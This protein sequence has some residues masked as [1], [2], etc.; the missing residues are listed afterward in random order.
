[1]TRRRPSTVPL[2]LEIDRTELACRLFEG[3]SDRTRYPG[4]SA[5]DILSCM[6]DAQRNALFRAAD[7]AV[8]CFVESI[9]GEGAA[10]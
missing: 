1:M 6:S 9:K 3:W 5:H 4:V 7:A 8:A 2:I 10:S